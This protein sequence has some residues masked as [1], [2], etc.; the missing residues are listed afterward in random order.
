MRAVISC[1]RQPIRSRFTKPIPCDG[2][3]KL[4][5]RSSR[6]L[7]GRTN[8]NAKVLPALPISALWSTNSKPWTLCRCA[9]HSESRRRDGSVPHQLQ[10]PNVVDSQRDWTAYWICWMRPLMGWRRR[11]N[12][13]GRRAVP[14]RRRLQADDSV[15]IADVDRNPAIEPARASPLTGWA[16]RRT[17][18]TS[19][20]QKKPSIRFI[21]SS[22]YSCFPVAF[23]GAS[24]A[25]SMQEGGRDAVPRPLAM[26]SSTSIACST[27]SRSAFNSANIFVTSISS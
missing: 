23:P 2:W 16:Y 15:T 11:G 27:A 19:F 18:I 10:P 21:G 22:A 14:R 7:N 12:N 9:V 4:S 20:V 3:R 26:R 24:P 5:A 6:R 8:S 17:S 25:T 13:V 1:H